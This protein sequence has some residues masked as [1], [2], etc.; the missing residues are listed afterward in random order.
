MQK[1][2]CVLLDIVTGKDNQDRGKVTVN[3]GNAILHEESDYH[4][5]P[6][7]DAPT[8]TIN[9]GN[10]MTERR[11]RLKQELWQIA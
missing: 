11:K 2:L 10:V 3:R 7:N 6:D 4:R 5:Y 1:I 9:T 8:D